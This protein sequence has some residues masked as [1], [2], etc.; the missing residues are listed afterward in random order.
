MGE[1]V[2]GYYMSER[3]GAGICFGIALLALGSGIYCARTGGEFSRGIGWSVLVMCGL[4]LAASGTYFVSLGASHAQF[5]AL[6]R[7]DLTRF[8]V[9]E[10]DHITKAASTLRIVVLA[11]IAIAF[12]GS[13]VAIAGQTRQSDIVR[14]AGIGITMIA[15]L[16]AFYDLSNR[17][18]ALNYKEKLFN[19][20]MV[21]R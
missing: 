13:I 19:K 7:T 4:L 11:E 12:A 17:E 21:S 6:L 15:L 3:R 2:D 14:G 5:A 20:E 8:F 1:V 10:T 9:D 16:L 18:R